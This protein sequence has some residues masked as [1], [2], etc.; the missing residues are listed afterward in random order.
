MYQFE[1]IALLTSS[2]S[3]VLVKAE[4]LIAVSKL[5]IRVNLQ[6]FLYFN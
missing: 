2:S 3:F 1:L 6:F 5:E 4:N